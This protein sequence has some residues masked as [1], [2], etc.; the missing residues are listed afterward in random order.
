V[1]VGICLA[2]YGVP[3]AW[4]S[5]DLAGLM[6]Y[7]AANRSDIELR[8][9]Q[10]TGTWIEQA[11]HR[12][13]SHALAAECDWLLFLD[14][15]MRFPPDTLV[16]LLERGQTVVAANYTTR[17]MP[18]VPSAV[19]AE[20]VRCYTEFASSGLEEVLTAGMGVM[21]VRSD[22]LRRIEPP[23]FMVG[24]D[25]RV[26]DYAGEDAYFC[27]KLRGIGATIWVD[28]DLS[29]DVM[30]IGT[31]E[32]EQHHAVKLKHALVVEEAR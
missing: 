26:M 14:D 9:F 1:R 19:K 29:Q 17:Q 18:F 20:G 30:H 8:R 28:H 7:T 16:R 31:F 25:T 2:S 23:W 12:T 24:W 6:G 4:F 10:C 22:L 15:D 21:L 5:Y 13:V 27:G 32:F 11:R 3:E